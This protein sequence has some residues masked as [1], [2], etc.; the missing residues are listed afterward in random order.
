MFFHSF[1][2][3]ISLWKCQGAHSDTPQAPSQFLQWKPLC[4][5]L[6]LHKYAKILE[7]MVVFYESE[8]CSL[9]E[10]IE[11]GKAARLMKYKH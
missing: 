8:H 4:W 9:M 11:T 1:S 10:W 3:L 7:V 2:I 6:Y 5:S